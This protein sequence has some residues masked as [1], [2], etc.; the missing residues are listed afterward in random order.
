MSIPTPVSWIKE[1]MRLAGG[2]YVLDYPTRDEREGLISDFWRCAEM[3]Y[4]PVASRRMAAKLMRARRV[5]LR[6]HPR[7]V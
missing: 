4:G 3:L 1:C 6:N 2:S 7:P 5:F